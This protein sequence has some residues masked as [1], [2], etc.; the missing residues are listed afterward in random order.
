MM[1]FAICFI[2][3]VGLLDVATLQ[4]SGGDIAGSRQETSEERHEKLVNSWR[5][6][7]TLALS[8]LAR[9][10]RTASLMRPINISGL[11]N[12]DRWK[13]VI[14]EHNSAS[15]V[16]EFIALMA[17]DLSDARTWRFVS[18]FHLV[19]TWQEFQGGE[20]SAVTIRN[21]QAKEKFIKNEILKKFLR[22]ASIDRE[23][24][25]VNLTFIRALIEYG[26]SLSTSPK[27]FVSALKSFLDELNAKAPNKK[28]EIALLQAFV[29]SRSS[30]PRGSSSGASSRETGAFADGGAA[31]SSAGAGESG[32][33]G[34]S[35][36]DSAAAS[37]G[38][39]ARPRREER[40]EELSDDE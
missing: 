34:G 11:K 19:G 22:T 28:E 3:V 10:L 27:S 26:E 24:R 13:E 15:A 5:E 12:A 38:G 31:V 30:E 4:A 32:V 40:P 2:F 23:V 9:D 18:D 36:A 29:D 20:E 17:L 39:F 14:G 21:M 7:A 33:Y 37:G 16:I 8:G 35:S 25:K 1:K 6:L